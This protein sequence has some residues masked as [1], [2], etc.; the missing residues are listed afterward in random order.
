L[1]EELS[2]S[3]AQLRRLQATGPVNQMLE[4]ESRISRL[5]SEIGG[6]EYSLKQTMILA[7]ADGVIT[8]LDVRGSGSVLQPGQ[9]VA[10]LAPADAPL[11][12]E[13]QVANRDIAFIERGLPVKLKFDAFPFQDY[14]VLNGA[15]VEISPDAITQEAPPPGA[16]GRSTT[17]AQQSVSFY[18]IVI[19][20]E[21]TSILAKGKNIDL[22]PGLALTAE[23][24]TERKSVL[25]L[26]LDPF[27][28]L[29]GDL[30]LS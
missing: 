14:E 26:I 13:A 5:Q 8:T 24:I 6:V 19:R 29:K 22:K 4:Q 30:K 23:I 27:R 11:V 7:P 10:L 16:P 20:P 2:T 12:V 17:P 1:Q 9:R 28:K 3:Q 25:N 21:K 18:K 15:V